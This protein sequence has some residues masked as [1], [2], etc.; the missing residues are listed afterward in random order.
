[1]QK[2]LA[3][4][5]AEFFFQLQA[6]CMKLIFC[7]IDAGHKQLTAD[8]VIDKVNGPLGGGLGDDRLLM[9]F[10]AR[11]QEGQFAGILGGS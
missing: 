3:R 9:V 7:R 8:L 5:I 11:I 1:M 4:L 10:T 2:L 6:V